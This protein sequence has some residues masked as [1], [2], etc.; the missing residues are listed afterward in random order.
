MNPFKSTGLILLFFIAIAAHGAFSA[1][2]A[3][4]GNAP[5]LNTWVAP[6]AD[7]LWVPPG[8]PMAEKPPE[9]KESDIPAE[10]LQSGRK[11]KLT[12]IIEVAL[13]NNPKTRATWHAAKASAADW[14]SKKGEYYPKIDAGAGI[15]R[16][17]NLN[18]YT[19][20]KMG[21]S[22][23]SFDTALELSWLVFDFGGRDFAAK[24]KYQALIAADFTHNAEIQKAVSIV[25]QTYFQYAGEKALVQASQASIREA[26]VTLESA[27][28]RH[29]NGVATIA[30]VLQA[31][32]ALSQ[33]R[34]T[35]VEFQGR[36]D[37]IRGVLATA[38]GLPANTPYDIDDLPINPPIRRFMDQVETC[39]QQAQVN[40]PDLAAQ[41]SRVEQAMA[42]I[43]TVRS[44]LYPSLVLDSRLNSS[45][46]RGASDWESRDT[47]ALMVNIP[48]FKGN[49]RHYDVVKAQH[50]AENQKNQMNSLEQN[51]ALQVWSSYFNLKTSEQRLNTSGDLLTSATQS[52]DVALGR[53]KE[54]VGG[55]LDLLAAQSAL[56]NARAKRIEALADWYISYARLAEDTGMLWQ[57]DTAK[58]GG[59]FDLFPNPT[60]KERQP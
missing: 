42:H 49:S 3:H 23:S 28:Q 39:I 16:A 2:C 11:W 33:A 30:D 36:V 60:T 44:A 51:I 19:K 54:G 59:V 38:M 21:P 52:H 25:L 37:T 4:H 55:F 41:R 12:D 10:L 56:E 46:D 7:R 48:L 35:L 13:R 5:E 9:S 6:S 40:R 43:R 57:S 22:A 53:Y 8:K 45:I 50:D 15:S 29:E 1:G 34:L 31:K 58:T 24:E 17:E 47:T 27:R 32:T 20:T 14:F 26:E 18:A